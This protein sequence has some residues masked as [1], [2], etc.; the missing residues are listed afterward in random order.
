MK[1]EES[2]PNYRPK[3]RE[4]TNYAIKSVKNVCK[5]YGPRPVGSEAEKQ[6]QEYMVN[7]L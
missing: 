2:M 7:D 6:A 5:A 3:V 1:S 4:Y